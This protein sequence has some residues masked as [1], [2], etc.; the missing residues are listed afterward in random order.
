MKISA[1]IGMVN[2]INTAPLY[3]MWRQTVRRA[4]WQVTEAPPTVLN[5]MLHENELDLGFVSSQEYALHPGEYRILSDLSISATGTVGS[6]F[7]FSNVPF[8]RLGECLVLL[9]SQS[10]TSVSLV[11]IILEE[12]Y[13]ITPRY[14]VSMSSETD[15]ESEKPAAVLAIGDE[16]LRLS[17]GGEY[18]YRLDL[19]EAWQVQTGLPFVFAV[20]AVRE[21]FY[22][23]YPETVQ[24]IHKELLRCLR[25]GKE[26]LR[27][28][29]ALVAGRVPMD[30]EACFQ[31][32]QGIE[33][34]LGSE[35]QEALIR[36][37]E[38]LVSRGEVPATALPLKVCGKQ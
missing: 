5:R 11:K 21:E 31:Y 32:L 8:S 30:A 14:R 25:A 2:Y 19:G 3:E 9:S 13:R 18:L 4:D 10:Q 20:W 38:Y 26:Q 33:Y 29:S 27:E 1:R 37:F 36:F 6:V 23:K 12:F 28:I 22:R 24:A 16:A 15:A 17:A 7:L 35:K 34:D